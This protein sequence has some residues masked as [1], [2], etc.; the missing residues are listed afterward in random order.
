MRTIFFSVD[1]RQLNNCEPNNTD[2]EMM[3]QQDLAQQMAGVNLSSAGHSLTH[4]GSMPVLT[5]LSD[6]S[7]ITGLPVRFHVNCP[8]TPMP[9][10]AITGRNVCLNSDKTIAVRL[11]EEYCNGY[12]FTN[13]PMRMGDKF[14]IQIL[15]IDKAYSGGLT[16]GMTACDPAD[17][18]SDQLPDDSDLLLDRP[19]Y[20]VVNKDVCSAPEVGDELSFHMT[21]EGRCF[22]KFITSVL[23]VRVT[24]LPPPP[25]RFR[26]M[27]TICFE[28]QKCKIGVLVAPQIND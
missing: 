3:Y 9:F 18:I 10:H 19:E 7:N 4:R 5:H 11:V 21:E 16:F 26:H 27:L 20:W 28:T 25:P 24:S 13:R 23:L 12:V 17:I 6:S 8:F 2:L 22:L 1:G 14:V 15:A